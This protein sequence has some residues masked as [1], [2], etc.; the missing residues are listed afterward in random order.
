M[1]NFSRETMQR[2]HKEFM[3]YAEMTEGTDALRAKYPDVNEAFKQANSKTGA[4]YRQEFYN[5]RLGQHPSASVS[6]I[7]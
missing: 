7:L 6:I 5:E 1:A 4:Q 2:L 3:P